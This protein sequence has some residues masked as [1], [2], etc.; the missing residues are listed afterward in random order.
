MH[1]KRIITCTL[2][3]LVPFFSCFEINLRPKTFL[4]QKALKELNAVLCTFEP[5][6]IMLQHVAVGVDEGRNNG[7]QILINWHQQNA[8][9]LLPAHFMIP[10]PWGTLL[11][12]LTLAN[13]LPTQCHTHCLPSA[14]YI[15]KQFSS[16]KKTLPQTAGCHQKLLWQTQARSRLQMSFPD[17]VSDSLCRNSLVLQTSCCISCVAGWSH[18]WSCREK[19]L[20]WRLWAGGITGGLLLWDWLDVLLMLVKRPQLTSQTTALDDNFCSYQ[21]NCILPQNFK[22]QWHCVVYTTLSTGP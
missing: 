7:P 14:W 18:G 22:H 10:P 6:I 16:V 20:M 21:G 3:F 4:I 12:T 9:V 1:N 17:M 2:L 8:P 15:E 19:C 5:C 11:T 13:L